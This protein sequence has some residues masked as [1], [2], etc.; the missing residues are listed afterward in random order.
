MTNSHAS[1]P[2]HRPDNDP[3]IVLAQDA[4]V[5]MKRDGFNVRDAGLVGYGLL[6]SLNVKVGGAAARFVLDIQER[7]QRPGPSDSDLP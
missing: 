1:N 3:V 2:E 4:L 5:R 7:N 6:Y